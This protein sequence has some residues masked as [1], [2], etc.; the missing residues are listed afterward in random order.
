[1]RRSLLPYLP[2]R[3]VVRAEVHHP[4]VLVTPAPEEF[5]RQIQGKR[6][7]E[8]DR[9]GKLL[10]F[11]LPPFYLLIHLGMTGQIT[12]RDPGRADLPFQRHPHTG[13]Q[14]TLQHP[15]DQHTHIVLHFGDGCALLYR[16]IRKFGKWRWIH[17]EDSRLQAELARVG[18]DPLTSDWQY[19]PFMRAASKSERA[20]KAILLD[21]QVCAG[22]GNIYADEALFTAGIRPETRGCHLSRARLKKLFA[23]VPQVL[24]KGLAAGGTSFSDYVDADG[25]KG[26]NQEQLL[27]YGRY[28]QPCFKCQQTLVRSTVAQRTSSWCKTCQ[29][30]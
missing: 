10:I 16:D 22:V 11:Q 23:A 18:T 20:I 3:E 30:P 9:R 8:L 25:K 21:Q 29:K 5:V 1:M 7:E 6:F 14:R 28:G 27:V 13:L 17:R 15:V 19:E 2:G 24:R 4:K 26:S 12:F